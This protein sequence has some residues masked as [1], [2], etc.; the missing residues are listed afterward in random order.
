MNAL[1]GKPVPKTVKV[2][3]DGTEF[4]VAVW[5]ELMKIPYGKVASYADV[6][7]FIPKCFAF[8]SLRLLAG[9]LLIVRLPRRVPVT[10]LLLLFHA[11][12]LFFL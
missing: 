9:L 8:R 3:L 1:N 11:T 5:N 2:L 10:T 4:S 7:N 12:G 6:S